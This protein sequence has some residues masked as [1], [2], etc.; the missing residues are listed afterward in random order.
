MPYIYINK[1]AGIKKPSDLNG[2]RVGIQTWFT[3]AALW[4]RGVLEDDW[5]VDVCVSGSQKGLML[6]AGLGVTCVSQKA[7]ESAKRATSASA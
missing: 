1:H 3:S 4:Q 6:P 7:L 5:G 2:R